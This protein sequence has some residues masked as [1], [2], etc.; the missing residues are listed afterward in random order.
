MNLFRKSR[1]QSNLNILK[2][3]RSKKNEFKDE[4]V[5]ETRSN[6]EFRRKLADLEDDKIALEQSLETGFKPG[7]MTKLKEVNLVKHKQLMEEKARRD[8]EEMK[9][10]VLIGIDF[11]G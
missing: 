3:F 2:L 6:V 11:V 9:K 8:R 4:L 10:Q 5:N 1:T 7:K